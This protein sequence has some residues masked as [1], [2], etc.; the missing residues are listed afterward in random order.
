MEKLNIKV[1]EAE[2]GKQAEQMLTS[3]L[4]SKTAGFKDHVNRKPA[5][6]SLKD[7]RGKT[8]FKKFGLVKENNKQVFVR[9]ISIVMGKHGFIRHYG[10]KTTRSAGSRTRKNPRNTTYHFKS[11]LMKQPAK[12]FI[13]SAIKSSG[14]VQ[15][16]ARKAAESRAQIITGEI[17][18]SLRDFS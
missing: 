5:D 13:D 15:F 14:V 8:R 3:A 1:N 12:P 6:V 10:V 4:R 17:V 9:A 16:A 18:F 2:W 7:A 11:H